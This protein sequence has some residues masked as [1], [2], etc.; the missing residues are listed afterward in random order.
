[1]V[2]KGYS[3]QTPLA[4]VA[5]FR[6]RNERDGELLL[7]VRPIRNASSYMVE[8]STDCVKWVTSVVSRQARRIV[9]PNLVPGQLYWIRVRAVGGSTGYGE[10]SDPVCHRG[11]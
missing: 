7:R 9:V 1:V 4:K 8:I 6:V 11:L 2:R 3:A 10:W 5:G